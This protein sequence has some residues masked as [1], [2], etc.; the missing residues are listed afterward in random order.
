MQGLS[1]KVRNIIAGICAPFILMGADECSLGADV[2]IRDVIIN[3]QPNGGQGAC[4]AV[5]EL[6]CVEDGRQDLCRMALTICEN[7]EPGFRPP[8]EPAPP[9]GPPVCG[10]PLAASAYAC[11]ELDA[12]S[13]SDVDGAND[14][15]LAV[16][17]HCFDVGMPDSFVSVV[18]TCECYVPEPGYFEPQPGPRCF[19]DDVDA[20]GLRMD[21]PYR[22]ATQ[23]GASGGTGYAGIDED[24]MADPIIFM[25]PICECFLIEVCEPIRPPHPRPEPFCL[26][27]DIAISDGETLEFADSICSCNN[28]ELHCRS[29]V[30]VPPSDDCR[31][32]LVECMSEAEAS[33]SFCEEND[34]YGSCGIAKAC[35]GDFEERCFRVYDACIDN[36]VEPFPFPEPGARD[37][38]FEGD[39][40]LVHGQSVTASDGCNTCT[41]DDGK[42]ACTEMGCEP[43]P[44][45]MDCNG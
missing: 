33:C 20:S 23:G 4:D 21:E 11:A 45:P 13:R 8:Y 32:Q 24:A 25:E 37:C 1:R 30:P 38:V 41:C 34:D 26:L 40:R 44:D 19:G 28:G 29:T 12:L 27:D 10:V 43:D 18:E 42:M 16:D 35:L 6:L 15:A 36:G 7:Q 3:V 31:M 22:C 17:H 9:Y 2:K 5:K 14:L 39:M